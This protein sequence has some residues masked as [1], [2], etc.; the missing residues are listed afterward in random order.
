[1]AH[2]AT[3]AL[4][5]MATT[6]EGMSTAQQLFLAYGTIILCVGF[7]LGGMLGMLRMQKPSIRNLATA[8]VETLMQASMHLGLAFAVGLVSFA[9]GWATIGALLLVIGSGM[10]AL[11]VTLNWLQDVGDQFAEK[12]LGYIINSTSTFVI[13]PGL[14]ITVIGIFTNL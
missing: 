10:Q 3:V 5:A 1:M 9:S 11:G 14:I 6:V 12:S 13:M 8:H 4:C 7:A 2:H